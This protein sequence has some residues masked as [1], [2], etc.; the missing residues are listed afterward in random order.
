MASEVIELKPGLETVEQARSE[1][2]RLNKEWW[3]SYT[4][5]G[6]RSEVTKALHAELDAFTSEA[7]EKFGQSNPAHPDC[8][9]C[10]RASVFGGPG[11]ESSR[12]CGSGRRPHCSCDTCF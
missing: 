9:Q 8:L 10:L 1:Q 3:A 4:K 7:I 11:H 6:E 12:F 5:N 2:Q